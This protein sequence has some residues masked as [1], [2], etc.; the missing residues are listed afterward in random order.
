MIS[1]KSASEALNWLRN[2]N[3]QEPPE[4]IFLDLNMPELD[5]FDFL[6]S[7]NTLPEKVIDSTR[8]V[9]LTSSNSSQDRDLAFENKNVIQFITKPLKQS[10]IELLNELIS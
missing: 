6:E 7:F 8:I 10:D 4:V 5:G 1:Y 2:I 3:G 9:V